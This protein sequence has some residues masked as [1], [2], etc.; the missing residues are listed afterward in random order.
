MTSPVFPSR[1]VQLKERIIL[2]EDKPAV[3]RAW[4]EIIAAIKTLTE[5]CEQLGPDVRIHVDRV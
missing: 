4:N 1:F 5:E 3:I 2:E